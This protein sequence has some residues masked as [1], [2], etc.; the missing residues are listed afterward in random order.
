[1]ARISGVEIPSKKRSIIGL[2]YLYGIGKSSSSAIL[3]KAFID[4]NK[5]IM[6]LSPEEM[7]KIVRVIADGYKIEGDLRTEV[8]LNIKRLMDNG[9][10]RGRRHR[11]GLKV[12]GQNTRNSGKM[13]KS[14]SRPVANKKKAGK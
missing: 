10:Y 2:T 5:K 7:S 4:P 11:V 13:I 9:S 1:M 12:R 3:K 14:K 8:R 6:D